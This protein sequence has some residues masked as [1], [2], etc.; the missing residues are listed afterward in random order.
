MLINASFN[1][2]DN[3]DLIMKLIIFLKCA[4]RKKKQK[5]NYFVDA[6]KTFCVCLDKEKKS[7]LHENSITIS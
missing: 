2:K 6:Y 4:I 1:R 5:V 7:H 3:E